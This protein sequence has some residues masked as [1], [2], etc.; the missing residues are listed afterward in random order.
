MFKKL[1]TA[2]AALAIAATSAQAGQYNVTQQLYADIAMAEYAAFQCKY[3]DERNGYVILPA[4][5]WNR[6]AEHMSNALF[7]ME[8]QGLVD[9]YTGVDIRV[10][11]GDEVRPIFESGT[12]EEIKQLCDTIVMAAFENDMVME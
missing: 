12:N 2:A 4:K 8:M 11:V 10:A 9:S 6:V 1:A 5:K 3:V 7:N